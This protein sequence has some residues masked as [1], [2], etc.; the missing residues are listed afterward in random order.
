MADIRE[1]TRLKCD[2]GSEVF[3]ALVYLKF[4]SGGG[5]TTEPAGHRC[6]ACTGLVD[7]QRMIRLIEINRLRQEVKEKEAEIEAKDAQAPAPEV[8]KR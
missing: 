2:C 5:T 1:W 8:A 6:I 7:N 3:E 4:R